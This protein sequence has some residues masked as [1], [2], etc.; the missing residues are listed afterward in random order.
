VEGG[1]CAVNGSSVI[2][3]GASG[4]FNYAGASGATACTTNV[5]GDPV[6]GTAKACYIEAAPP[7]TDIW[8]QCATENASCSFTGVMA[9]AYGAN[10][11]YGY[12][13]L[14]SPVGCS[15][16]VFGDPAPG[17]AKAC[18]LMAPPPT[19]TT[20]TTC[21]SENGTC[22]F[23][24]THEVAYGADGRYFYGTFTGG[25]GCTNAVFGDPATGTA[26]NCYAQ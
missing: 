6:S 21:A 26:K 22:S 10:G 19:F 12:A 11:S 8:A 1:T 3:F 16:S 20:W 9:L 7:A 18:S 24:G 25:T 4:R 15:N 5:F 23:T 17:T 2:A 14:G 13:T